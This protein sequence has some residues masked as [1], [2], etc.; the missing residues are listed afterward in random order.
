MVTV[1]ELL[2]LGAGALA[3]RAMVSLQPYSGYATPPM[4]GD[5][6]AQ[7]HWQEVTVNLP[8]VHWY[9]QTADNDLKYWGLDYPP[10]TAYHSWIMGQI[11]K[12]IDPSWVQL[13]RSRGLTSP[14]HKIFMRATVILADLLI[15]IPA[16][17]CTIAI[18]KKIA[19][20][21][22]VKTPNE[23]LPYFIALFYPGQILI[24]NGHFQY[25]NCSLGLACFAIFFILCDLKLP[26]TACFVFALNYKQM[27]LYHALPFFCYLLVK[28][29]RPHFEIQNKF[30]KNTSSICA[31]FIQLCV[32]AFTVIALFLV[33]WEPW[34]YSIMDML[35]AV[36]RLFPF[37]RGVF[38]DK[39]S[40]VWCLIHIFDY[41]K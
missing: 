10:L 4:Y 34:L 17:L 8:I 11:A 6:E 35:G 41:A 40:N 27:E 20:E 25:N 32:L 38:E 13:H 9:Q 36:Q 1:S 7:R 33:I 18:I 39:V 22:K 16:L 23:L 15:Y 29:F 3:I 12:F 26:A 19:K 31:G 37:G 30:L 14:T 28:C 2:M 21:V 5:F 24:D